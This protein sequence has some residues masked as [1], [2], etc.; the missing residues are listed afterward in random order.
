MEG[1]FQDV[2]APGESVNLEIIFGPQPNT[3]FYGK[4]NLN[5]IA[6]LELTPGDDPS[7][8]PDQKKIELLL[9]Q[10]HGKTITVRSIFSDTPDG[11]TLAR[12]PRVT[13][14]QF[15]TSDK[16]PVE[17]VKSIDFR[18]TLRD[19]KRYLRAENKT[20]EGLGFDLTNFEVLKNKSTKLG[21][22]RRGILE[23][24]MNDYKLPIKDKLLGLVAKLKPS[25]R[26]Q[27]DDDGA[28][29]GIEGIIFTDPKTRE[30]FKVVNK[31][32]FTAINKFNYKVRN[33]ISSRVISL[34]EKLPVD[35]RG[36]IIGQA[37][38]RCV[39]LFGLEDAVLPAQ[40]TKVVGKLKGDT[41]EE[42]VE[43]IVGNLKQLSFEGIKRKM[44][45]I[46]VSALDDLDEALDDFKTNGDS[47]E[48]ELKDGQKIKYTKEIKRR[49]LMSFAESRRT[50]VETITEIRH[51]GDFYDLV[52]L[53]LDKAL[54]KVHEEKK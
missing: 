40:V 35:E 38:A 19:L 17:D 53:F 30:R 49:T 37:R 11:R 6:L 10:L 32:I 50:L 22:E 8:M 54:D 31:D 9:K 34:D 41:R 46:Y 26:G 12:A 39:K 16:V 14:W 29:S 2:L 28:Y 47:Y 48:L 33:A 13:D 5:Y 4:D 20:A 15:T 43:S 7:S 23:T 1:V 36:G 52:E 44:Q 3:V 18:D 21:D 24:L 42:T 27:V 25:L 51:A 45:S